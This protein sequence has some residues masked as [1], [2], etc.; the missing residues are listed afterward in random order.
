MSEPNK[1]LLPAEEFAQLEA[2]ELQT[3]LQLTTGYLAE[4]QSKMRQHADGHY[5]YLQA[6]EEF[7]HYKSIASTLQTLLRTSV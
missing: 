7:T 2:F 4:S 5:A 1:L 6:K 3:A